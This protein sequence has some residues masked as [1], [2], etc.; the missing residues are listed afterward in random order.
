VNGK[1]AGSIIPHMPGNEEI[2]VID[3]PQEFRSEN[4]LEVTVKGIEG[5]ASPKI[6]EI[7][8]VK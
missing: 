2:H 1:E 6:Y 4:V 7:R 5:K 8:I 3:I